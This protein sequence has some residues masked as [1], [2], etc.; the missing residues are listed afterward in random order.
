M[1]VVG[2]LLYVSSQYV[3][4]KIYYCV[5][6]ILL[7]FS[8]IRYDVGMDY[9]NYLRNFEDIRNNANSR[10]EVMTLI[11]CKLVYSFSGD[12]QL[13]F[14]IYSFIALVGV[15]YFVK[16]FSDYKELSILIFFS[17]GIYYL[18]T[19]NGIRQWAAI[20]MFLMAL[21]NIVKKKYF[22]V[23]ILL[24]LAL[25]FHSSAII[26]ILLLPIIRY[27]IPP[28]V[29]L[30]VFSFGWLLG[31]L[32][33]IA[34]SMT[35]YIAYLTFLRP[36]VP[37]SIP[38]TILYI[39]VLVYILYKC[40]Y[41]SSAYD[42]TDVRLTILLNMCILSI[43]V[44]FIGSVVLGIDFMSIMRVNMYFELQLIILIPYIISKIESNFK[45]QFMI[46]AMVSFCLADY[47]GLI[48]FGGEKNH[49][50][51]YQTCLDFF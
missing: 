26:I 16:E 21:P 51:P 29:L 33:L 1:F 25:S 17:I 31:K 15:F 22:R 35:S 27:K 36:N 5:F 4:N 24:L 20:A 18:S 23:S 43:F 41:F 30:L 45:R 13:I 38:S 39:M 44:V 7:L 42:K 28:K 48:V 9:L 2:Y 47:T 14:F 10:F 46:I 37:V 49:I 12:S 40:N 32:V 8:G 50:V 6:I 3:D 34:I 19:F 11:I